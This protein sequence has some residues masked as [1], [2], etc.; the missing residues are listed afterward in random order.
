MIDVLKTAFDVALDKPFGARPGVLDVVKCAMASS[1]GPK[2]VGMVAKLRFII[3]LKNESDYFLEQFIRPGRDAERSHL[4]VLLRDMY[5]SNSRPSIAF[6]AQFVYDAFD[7]RQVH[8]IHSF[9]GCPFG[10]R[11]LVGRQASVC[12]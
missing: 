2:P 7:F 8:P 9:A 5:A 11:S 12:P 4:P 1:C 6:I 3:R 10:H